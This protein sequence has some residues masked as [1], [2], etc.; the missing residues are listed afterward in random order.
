MALTRLPSFTLLNTDSFT[1]ANLTL[2]SN[3]TASNANL[4]NAVSANYFIGNGS[5]LT[6]L[7]ATVSNLANTVTVN[8]QP[9]ITSVGIL[10]SLEVSGNTVIGGNLTV[11]GTVTSIN[12]TIVQIDDLAIVLA[13]DASTS[14]QANGA[15]II[16]NGASANML[17][18]NTSNS[19]VF[20][21]KISADGSLLSNL[22]A[23][24]I[25]GTVANATYA[26]TA[27]TA[28]SVA[29]ANVTGTVAN[30][31]YAVTAGTANSVAVAN[32]T[33]IGNIATVN[34]DGNSSNIL[35]GNGVFASAPVTY[36]DSNVATYLPTYTGNLSPGNL[37]VSGVANLGAV[38][39]VKIS[40]GTTGQYLQTD[41]AGNL[42]WAAA[43]G[44]GGG[45]SVTVSSTPPATPSQGDLWLDSESGE[46]NVYFGGAWGSVS[47]SAPQLLSAVNA[48]TGDSITTAYTLTTTPAAK[49]YTLV[50]VGGVLQPRTTYSL[51]GNVLTFSSAVPSNTPIEVTILGGLA[52]PIGAA[53][54]VTS[55]TQANITSVGTL[56]GLNVNGNV[57]I[58]GNL[59][60]N[61]APPATTGKA[62]A[63]AIVFG[64]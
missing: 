16:I 36:G 17:Y 64:F 49:E 47:D 44:G 5:Y 41:G 52:S 56:T 23:A 40:G 42:S 59:T 39:N 8:A 34:K 22:T 10:A 51:S 35:Y 31:T 30:A 33:G 28:N 26:V 58:T 29:G 20:S 18:I 37:A 54:T 55:N 21:H 7:S 25:T 50:A 4:G 2:T 1:F 63:M 53:A 60:V 6:G 61:N 57:A 43:A 3:V 46:L 38:A 15:G 48:F 24:N 32:V 62:I 12:S 27:G 11:N 19:F 13:N 9:N 14:S 45:A